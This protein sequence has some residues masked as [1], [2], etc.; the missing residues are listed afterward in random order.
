MNKKPTMLSLTSLFLAST[1][2]VS[3]A[4]QVGEAKETI[5]ST[6]HITVTKSV[7]AEVKVEE[8]IIPQIEVLIVE[9]LVVN[10]RPQIDNIP[11]TDRLLDYTYNLSESYEVPYE[12]IL[13]IIA[14]ESKFD[15]NVI[16]KTSDYGLAQ[17]NRSNINNFAKG[18]EIKSVKPLNP[19]HNIKMQVYY[20]SHLKGYFSKFKMSEEQKFFMV[21]LAYNRGESGAMKWVK[22]RGWNN[23][24]VTKVNNMKNIIETNTYKGE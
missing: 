19:E 20:L 3:C 13:A 7:M 4:A 1:L 9:E 12:L 14:V 2:L 10:K 17:I 21:V 6:P 22:S 8:V 24:Y 5:L 18:A 23:T 16:S 15:P 11:L